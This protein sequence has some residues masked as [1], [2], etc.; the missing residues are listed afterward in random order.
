MFHPKASHLPFPRTFCIIFYP[1]A[2]H[3]P[4]HHIFF[5]ILYAKGWRL[6]LYHIFF[7]ILHPTQRIAAQPENCLSHRLTLASIR[8]LW[9]QP[10][11]QSWQRPPRHRHRHDRDNDNNIDH[12]RNVTM[13]MC[14]YDFQVGQLSFALTLLHRAFQPSL[15][16]SG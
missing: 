6:R 15:S 2:S 14:Q 4:L 7:S 16:K 8:V 5:K 12:E 3:W 9:L 13:T 1:N 10:W 11:R